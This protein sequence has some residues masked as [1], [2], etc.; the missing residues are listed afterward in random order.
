MM[1]S[2][3]Y[4]PLN[5]RCAVARACTELIG[6]AS[7]REWYELYLD[8]VHAVSSHLKAGLTDWEFTAKSTTE[9]DAMITEVLNRLEDDD[10]K[11]RSTR[12]RPRPTG[13]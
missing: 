8:S 2:N 4:S 10:I 11:P 7:Y 5:I 9:V 1:S 3:E 13:L 6:W 12:S